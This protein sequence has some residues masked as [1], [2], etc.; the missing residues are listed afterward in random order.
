H[1][2]F[3]DV[4]SELLAQARQ[5]LAV[6]KVS[7]IVNK[8]E[9]AQAS[10]DTLQEAAKAAGMQLVHI[11]AVDAK[12]LTPDGTKANL[13]ASPQF[14]TQAFQAEVGVVGDPF[15]T[16]D[17]S[18]YVI[19]VGGVEP[20][21]LKPLAQV[22]AAAVQDWTA[23]KMDAALLAK[24]NSLTAQ[25]NHDGSL[26]SV[27]KALKVSIAHSPGL[28]RGRPSPL[29]PA[30]VLNAIFDAPPG[31]AVMGKAPDGKSFV[32]ARVTGIAHPPAVIE[33]L[34]Q[35]AQFKNQLGA[36][37]GA[38]IPSLF[39]QAARKRAGVTI[40]QKNLSAIMGSG[41]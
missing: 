38:D 5:Q 31:T 15:Q 34:P 2:S 12:G 41:S 30:S 39:A 20:P 3:D 28:Q 18:A 29:F 21:K 8:F 27:A 24:A 6:E 16:T 23:A 36:Q 40:N 10:G 26:A 32:I 7:D 35:Y 14:L 11:K 1:K 25:A 13:P 17:G 9:D 19:K 4:K 33:K 37:I 22:R